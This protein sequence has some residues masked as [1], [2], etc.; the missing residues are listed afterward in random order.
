MKGDEKLWG[1]LNEKLDLLRSMGR[2]P[3]AL[4][5]GVAAVELARRAFS[6]DAPELALALAKL[7]Q[8]YDQAGDKAAAKSPLVEAHQILL[9][10]EARN[11]HAIYRSAGRVALL[12]D[13][14]GETEEAIRYYEQAI[15]ASGQ[16]SD[17]PYADL[18]MML[19]NVALAYKRSGRQAA[20]EPYYLHALEL[21]ETHL[22]VD[23]PDV[24]SVLNNLAV[25]YTSQQRFVEAEVTHLRALAIREKIHQPAHSDI[26]QSKC[27]LGV[28]YH[29][30][31]NYS[32]ASE[33][34]QDSLEA[35]EASAEK[36][37]PDYEVVAANYADLLR[38][39]GKTRQ[40]SQLEH[41]ATKRRR[42]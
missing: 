37:P 35:W 39:L 27:N 25:F 15:A 18:G 11:E 9:S 38:S 10:A 12:C 41:R 28:V 21:Y 8:L 22:G 3:E 1:I 24:A 32:R 16:L 40:A 6:P 2:L 33:L 29:S 26:A 14:L 4:R 19:N 30:S 23:H 20:A 17:L 36:P 5:V 42:A 31:G 34:Y 13:S 7:G